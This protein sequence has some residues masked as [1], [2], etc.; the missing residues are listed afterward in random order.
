MK[1]YQMLMVALAT[2]G[3]A[4]GAWAEGYNKS[5]DNQ[6]A[7]VESNANMNVQAS[8]NF[9]SEH[10]QN[11]QEKLRNEGHR[12]STDGIWGPQT[13]SALRD[14]QRENNLNATGTLTNETLAALD[15][16]AKASDM[17]N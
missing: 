8:T 1:K 7:Q 15:M 3:L 4:S 5:N 13:A 16:D 9:D 11:I 17:A 14:F 12:V 2:T 6:G 10:I